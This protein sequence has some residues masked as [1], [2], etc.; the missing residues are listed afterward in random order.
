MPTTALPRSLAALVTATIA[1]TFPLA[2]RVEPGRSAGRS[3]ATTFAMLDAKSHF[4]HA[5]ATVS[6]YGWPVKP[7]HRPHAVRGSFGDPRVGLAPSGVGL[8]YSFHTGVDVVADD[9]TPVYAT[10]SGRVGLDPKNP[11]AVWI[12]DGLGTSFSYWHVVPAVRPGERVTAYETIVGHVQRPWGHVHFSEIHDGAFQ[13]PLRPGAMGPYIDR[14]VPEVTAVTLEHDARPV[15]TDAAHGSLDVIAQ[16]DDPPANPI[17]PPWD[18]LAV[19]PAEVRWRVVGPHGAGTRWATAFDVTRTI[20]GDASYGRVFAQWTRQNHPD[21]GGRYRVYLAHALL[22]SEL[23]N[24]L[25]RV[26]VRASDV[27]GNRTTARA[28]LS[29]DNGSSL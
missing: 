16:V 5:C 25:Y 2:F 9:G 1:L 19:M 26:D 15:R 4:G 23:P 24:G 10:L 27:C 3:D 11:D 18:G 20:P 6:S 17:A 12:N 13:N 14:T 21:K 22:T 28:S 29:I 7:F 8:T